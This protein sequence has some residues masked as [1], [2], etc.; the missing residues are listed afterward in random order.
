MVGCPG[1]RRS[2][3]GRGGW[4]TRTRY[5]VSRLSFLFWSRVLLS[6]S[7]PLAGL[8]K[9]RVELTIDSFGLVWAAIWI[10]RGHGPIG[11]EWARLKGYIVEYAESIFNS[12]ET[13]SISTT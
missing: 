10:A 5:T 12:M 13:S 6:I 9:D 1:E 4:L 7:V 11:L 3:E 8:F 2:G